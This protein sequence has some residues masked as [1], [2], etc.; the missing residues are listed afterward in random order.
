MVF[1]LVLSQK[2]ISILYI[3]FIL[4]NAVVVAPARSVEPVVPIIYASKSAR[5][6]PEPGTGLSQNDELEQRAG[7]DR[8]EEQ[9]LLQ[10][11]Q[12]NFI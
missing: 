5:N 1:F 10:Q 12:V 7:I 8:R 3:L 2:I 11:C 4:Q 9:Q 6:Q